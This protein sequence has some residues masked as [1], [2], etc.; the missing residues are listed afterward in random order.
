MLLVCQP[1]PKGRGHMLG[2]ENDLVDSP[3]LRP[4]G[5]S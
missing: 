3:A 2:T 4:D 5:P 1:P